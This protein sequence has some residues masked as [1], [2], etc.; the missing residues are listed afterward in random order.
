MDK[1]KFRAQNEQT[2]SGSAQRSAPRLRQ[3]KR[4]LLEEAPAAAST[5]ETKLSE[6]APATASTGKMEQM[7]SG[8]GF[9]IQEISDDLFDRMIRRECSDE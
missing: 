8:E 2:E 1:Q 9:S 6:E 5:G 3:A 4:K 7:V